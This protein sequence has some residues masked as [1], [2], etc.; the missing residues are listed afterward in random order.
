MAGGGKKSDNTLNLISIS[1]VKWLFYLQI[2][3]SLKM[4]SMRIAL[5]FLLSL[6]LLL[7]GSC[8]RKGNTGTP[9][10]RVLEADGHV[11]RP[12][13]FQVQIRSTG[14]LLSFEDVE[15]RT[16]VA[17]NVLGIY[18]EE[19]QQVRQGDLLVEMDNRTWKAQKTGLEARLA[20]TKSELARKKGLL[21]VE[22]VS[23]EEVERTQAE[24]IQLESQIGELEVLIDR[25]MIRA[26]FNGRLGMRD[27]SPGAYLAQG[28][29][30]TRLVQTGR[31]R[32]HFS[33]PAQYA[34]LARSGQEVLLISSSTG[35]T[36]TAGIYAVDPMIR[37]TSRSLQV[38]ALLENGQGRFVPGDFIQVEMVVEDN[39]E[40]LLVPAES[41]IPELGT[42]V[43]YLVREGQAVKQE[44]KTGSRT[45]NRVQVLHGLSPGDVVLTTGLMEVRDGV[46][47]EVRNMERE[48]SP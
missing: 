11:V 25:S 40:A 44:V 24:V 28:D 3:Q 35:D 20:F 45:S 46:P 38:R 23:L 27:F 2:I 26:P 13:P 22:G 36:A 15:L 18:F 48:E 7:L 5:I 34:S 16:P 29:V 4:N 41:V 37:A 32:V 47:V 6:P 21:S 14:E 42:Q 43:V 12:E 19:G 39:Q 33:I 31:I 17:G 9:G 1:L 8:Q 10:Q 30:I